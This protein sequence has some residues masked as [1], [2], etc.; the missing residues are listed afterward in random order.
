[1]Q[2]LQEALGE[3]REGM[4]KLVSDQLR[5]GGYTTAQIERDA[6]VDDCFEV[7]TD[8]PH[9]EKVQAQNSQYFLYERATHVF[10]E[11]KRVMDF[12]ETCQAE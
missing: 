10:G 8:V 4:L 12:M 1:M 7:V 11:T 2:Q 5:P 3:T 6:N 9:I